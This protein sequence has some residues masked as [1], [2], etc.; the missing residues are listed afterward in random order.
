MKTKT[1]ADESRCSHC[2]RPIRNHYLSFRRTTEVVEFCPSED[3]MVMECEILS[4]DEI[5]IYC[6]ERCLDLDLRDAMANE[7]I[8]LTHKSLDMRPVEI[9]AACG[10]KFKVRQFHTVYEVEKILLLG[11]G[12]CDIEWARSIAVVC[13]HCS[14][15]DEY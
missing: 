5:A 6:S 14:P 11:S 3:G 10:K 13:G 8:S 1:N 7:G 2:S 15:E 9:C 4:S 12:R